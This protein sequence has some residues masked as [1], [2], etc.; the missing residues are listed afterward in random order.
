MNIVIISGHPRADSFTQA[1]ARSYQKGAEAGGAAAQLFPLSEMNLNTEPLG[2]RPS[3]ENWTNEI[4]TLWTAI[5][6]ADHLVIAH[7]LWWGTMPAELKSLLDR[8]LLP[9][10]AYSFK[11]GN[12]LPTGHLKGKSA[13]VIM[14]SDTPDWYYRLAYGKAQSKLMKNQILKFVGLKP[15]RFT[16]VSPIHN[17]PAPKRQMHLNK[18]AEIARNFATRHKKKRGLNRAS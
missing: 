4:Y 16:H 18:V 11:Q 1:L 5:E 15:L 10:L 12:P 8:L 17:M 14:T 3:Q 6:Q 13:E 9:D 2:S 7:P